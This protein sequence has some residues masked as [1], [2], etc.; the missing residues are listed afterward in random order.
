LDKTLKGKLRFPN[1][2]RNDSMIFEIGQYQ[3]ILCNTNN[4]K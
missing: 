1:C 3:S 4:W 2:E